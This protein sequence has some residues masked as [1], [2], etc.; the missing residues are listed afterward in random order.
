MAFEADNHG[1][2]FAV[3]S[4]AWARQQKLPNFQIRDIG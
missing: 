4:T 1:L 2:S 3:H